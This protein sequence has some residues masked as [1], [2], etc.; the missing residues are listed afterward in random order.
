MDARELG[1][2]KVASAAPPVA[3][4][5]PAGNA[6]GIGEA[7]ARAPAD[8]AIVLFPELA[9]TGYTCEDLFFSDDLR[10]AARQALATLAAMADE[11]VLVV[12][13]PWWL[14]DGRMLDCAFVCRRGGI[15]GAVPKIALPNFDEFCERRWFASGAGVCVLV[16]DELGDFPLRPDLVFRLGDT[17]FGIEICE[18]LWAPSPPSAALA[19]AGAE[20]LLNL[21]ASPELVAKADYRRE[22]V[23]TQSARTLSGYVYAGAG[24]SESTKDVVFGG[25]LIGAEN[26]RILGESERFALGGG[27][28][29]VEL[30]CQRVRR[31]RVQNSTFAQSA[32]NAKPLIVDAGAPVPLTGQSSKWTFAFASASRAAILSAS[33]N[34]PVSST[35]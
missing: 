17:A 33:A 29:C 20:I 35:T 13:A 28:L 8:A 19:L 27:M 31:S 1:L 34:V 14:A 4:A 6:L 30:D 3:V 7:Y 26:G 23:R 12:G 9:V 32:R 2:V 21:S 11:R 10:R 5:D 25:H 22:L 24:P 18:D 16:E 15:L